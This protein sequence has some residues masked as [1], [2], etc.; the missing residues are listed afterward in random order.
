MIMFRERAAAT[1]SAAKLCR[2]YLRGIE[3]R[4]NPQPGEAWLLAL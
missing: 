1:P 3:P 2:C 4:G